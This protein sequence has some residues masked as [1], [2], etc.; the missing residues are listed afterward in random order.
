MKYMTLARK[1]FGQ[2]IFDSI[3]KKTVYG[4]FVAGEDKETIKPLINRLTDCG[5][6]SILDYAVEEDLASDE[7]VSREMDSCTGGDGTST[8]DVAVR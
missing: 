5:V 7:A 6:G 4:Q 2:K 3:M 8:G 1:I